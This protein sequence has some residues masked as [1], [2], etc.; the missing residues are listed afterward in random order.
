MIINDTQIIVEMYMFV[1][2]RSDG[3][4]MKI[5]SITCYVVVQNNRFSMY[6]WIMNNVF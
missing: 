2:Y 1:I 3:I 4:F 6:H 5:S